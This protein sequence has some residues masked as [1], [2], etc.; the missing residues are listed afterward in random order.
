MELFE[1]RRENEAMRETIQRMEFGSGGGRRH[2]GGGA[3]RSK[4]QVASN[5]RAAMGGAQK[6]GMLTVEELR[7][8]F[9]IGGSSNKVLTESLGSSMR[10]TTTGNI[11][12]TE[13]TA[14]EGEAPTAGVEGGEVDP[15]EQLSELLAE[16]K[17]LRLS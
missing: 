5:G 6:K 7:N 3:R 13:D 8:M 14:R 10:V 1:L 4:K 17:A 9:A 15:V 11:L 16:R 2:E 12:D